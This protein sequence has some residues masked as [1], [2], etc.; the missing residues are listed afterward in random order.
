MRGRRPVTRPQAEA[1]GT[2]QASL[3]WLKR[4]PVD[5]LKIDRSFVRD[6]ATDLQ[7]AAIVRSAVD[8]A[9]AF[10]LRTVAEGVEDDVCLRRT[11]ELGC[12]LIQ[13]Y[14]LSRPMPGDAVPAFLAAQAAPAARARATSAPA[15][16]LR[17]AA[18]SH[19]H[20]AHGTG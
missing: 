4:L 20:R 8:L 6:V 2:G 12:D 7:S 1:R 3:A 13:G 9:R 19:G 5:V 11:G 14:A 10:G 16:P 15:I 18:G 17:H